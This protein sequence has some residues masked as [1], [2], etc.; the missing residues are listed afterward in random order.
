MKTTIQKML[1]AKNL[2]DLLTVLLS[3]PEELT[4]REEQTLTH[5]PTFGGRAGP[6]DTTD[7]WSWDATR[8]LIGN[9]RGNA[10]FSIIPR[11]TFHEVVIKKSSGGFGEYEVGDLGDAYADE[12]DLE[13]M[14]RDELGGAMYEL[15]V[16]E[17]PEGIEDIRGRIHHQPARVFVAIFHPEGDYVYFGIVRS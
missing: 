10:R 17:L 16:D 5:L 4:A 14:M 2:D 15:G 9:T 3:L 6:G 1:D 7:V 8:L 13:K 12:S 11:H